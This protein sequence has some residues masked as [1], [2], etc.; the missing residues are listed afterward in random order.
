MTNKE[1]KTLAEGIEKKVEDI[2]TNFSGR[3]EAQ[4]NSIIKDKELVSKPEMNGA[5][6]NEV[7]ELIQEGRDES[8]AQFD[9]LKA[10]ILMM[11]GQGGITMNV[12][13]T[14]TDGGG[15]NAK[16]SRSENRLSSK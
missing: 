12:G 14:N 9:E 16:R 13:E 6:K 3:V 2:N 7:A 15:G 1:V 10:L 8:K 11:K 5:V 4:V